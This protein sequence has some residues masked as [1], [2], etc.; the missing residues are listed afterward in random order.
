MVRQWVV[1]AD[2][3]QQVKCMVAH[4]VERALAQ[5][6][7]LGDGVTH[8]NG[9]EQSLTADSGREVHAVVDG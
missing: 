7:Y 4:F 2:V 8:M 1:L 5:I 9:P 3:E 6:H